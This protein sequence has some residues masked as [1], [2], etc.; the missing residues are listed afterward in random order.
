M[1]AYLGQPER[2]LP[3]VPSRKLPPH[4]HYE[5]CGEVID[6]LYLFTYKW[7]IKFLEAN[8]LA[9]RLL[10]EGG[11]GI[12]AEL[13][14]VLY[15]GI[16][17]LLLTVIVGW[18]TGSSKPDQ[19]EIKD[20]A[21]MSK[22]KKNTGD[23]ARIEG[24][25]P[26]VI[27]ILKKAGITTFDQLAR[28]KAVDVQKALDAAGLQMMDPRGWISQAKLAAKGDWDGFDRL[29]GELKGGRKVK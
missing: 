24:I 10:A 27:K 8:M 14:W 15:A 26:K 2:F 17:F 11:D 7:V 6:M 23:L 16:A 5:N 12:N 22:G 13:S 19:P 29:K 18:W 4:K 20:E 28:A 9:L 25:G 1:A 3:F 21:A